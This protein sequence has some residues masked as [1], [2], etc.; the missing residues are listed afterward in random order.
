M[1]DNITDN[2]EIIIKIP[3]N[4]YENRNTLIF[5]LLNAANAKTFQEIMVDAIKN[6]TPLDKMKN[7]IM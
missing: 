4:I 2:I 1:T 7:K 3:K 5:P 6:S